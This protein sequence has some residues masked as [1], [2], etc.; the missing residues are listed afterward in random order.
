MKGAQNHSDG[1][2][3]EDDERVEAAK[4][5]LITEIEEQ[6]LERSVRKLVPVDLMAIFEL[7]SAESTI[8]RNAELRREVISF[9]E[10]AFESRIV[11]KMYVNFPKHNLTNLRRLLKPF[12]DIHS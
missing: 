11:A 8:D 7:K 10:I 6:S 2:G 1:E 4:K 12:D 5:A 9:V 3:F